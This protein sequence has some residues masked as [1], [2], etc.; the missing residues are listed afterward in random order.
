MY[1]DRIVKRTIVWTILFFYVLMFQHSETYAQ[2]KLT[3]LP[4]KQLVRNIV[5]ENEH[6]KFTIT[7]DK[8][9]KLSTAIDK[10]LNIDYMVGND[11]LMFFSQRHPLWLHDVG[12][13][14]FT[15]DD[16]RD[17]G[18]VSVSIIQQ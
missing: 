13:Q 4:N 3:Y 5:L 12:F 7:I 2:A 18:M 6:V 16:K 14:L 15:F 17:D 8:G 11:N 9:V 1:S 10:K